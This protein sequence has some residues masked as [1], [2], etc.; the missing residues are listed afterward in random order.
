[1]KKKEEEEHNL[2]LLEL[3]ALPQLKRK[4]LWRF[5]KLTGP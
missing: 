1:M 3:L 2:F 4:A 5:F